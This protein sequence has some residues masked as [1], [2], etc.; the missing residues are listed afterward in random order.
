MDE[1][2]LA[3]AI[4][5]RCDDVGLNAALQDMRRLREIQRL[6]MTANGRWRYAL[7]AV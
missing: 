3:R 7:G 2:Q 1:R 5:V 6:S 4:G